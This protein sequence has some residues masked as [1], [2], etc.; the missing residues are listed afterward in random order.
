VT[1]DLS[2][3]RAIG[4][5]HAAQNTIRTSH[6]AHDGTAA[7]PDSNGSARDLRGTFVAPALANGKTDA[8]VA[9]RT[10]HRSSQMI[11]R[12]RRQA[13][14]AKEL[15]LPTLA[16]LDWAIPVRGIPRDC[17]NEQWALDPKD[18]VSSGTQSKAEVAELAD[19]ADSKSVVITDLWVRF[20]PSA[21]NHTQA[22]VARCKSQE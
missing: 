6:A 14:S 15:S 19:A 20:P 8:W 4:V 7:T 13:R 2:F 3:D 17:P 10:G 11:N 9:D 1:L 12:Y 5:W 18:R 21:R 16:A 22:V